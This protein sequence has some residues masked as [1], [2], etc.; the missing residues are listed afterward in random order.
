MTG[1]V[2]LLA[3]IIFVAGD[4]D[5][6]ANGWSPSTRLDVRYGYGLALTFVAAILALGAGV[7]V[8]VFNRPLEVPTDQRSLSSLR[9]RDPVDR[10]HREVGVEVE[11]EEGGL[12]EDGGFRNPVGNLHPNHHPHQHH[13]YRRG[14]DPPPDY[15]HFARQPT[16]DQDPHQQQGL[17]PPQAGYPR[18]QQDDDVDGD[19]AILHGAPR[20]PHQPQRF[21]PGSRDPHHQPRFG[22]SAAAESEGSG[23][24]GGGGFGSRGGPRRLVA[25]DL[26]SASGDLGE[27]TP[28][29]YCFG[30]TAPAG[31]RHPHQQPHQQHGQDRYHM[32]P[33]ADVT[34]DDDVPVHSG[35]QRYHHHHQLQ[36]S[37]ENSSP[38]HYSSHHLYSPRGGDGGRGGGWGLP[39]GDDDGGGGGDY[40]AAADYDRP[41][42]ASLHSCGEDGVALR[43]GRQ[44]S[45][46]SSSTSSTPSHARARQHERSRPLPRQ[47]S[48]GSEGSSRIGAHPGRHSLHD[49]TAD[50]DW[51]GA[52]ASARLEPPDVRGVEPLEARRHAARE[53]S[54]DWRKEGGEG[55]GGGRGARAAPQRHSRD[56]TEADIDVPSGLPPPLYTEV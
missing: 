11:V 45:S 46:L 47:T 16:K 30:R 22:S 43:Y 34:D 12:E 8:L 1:G 6:I 5:H 49:V 24:G 9:N 39:N 28:S 54:R 50:V 42:P 3:A 36:Q 29:Y 35:L 2:T 21:Q 31:D 25:H 40:D 20:P 37:P 18:A 14:T 7:A 15:R 17:P 56:V 19:G 13:R 4:P 51:H 33:V 48:A 27:P 53:N 55:E 44:L 26:D 32:S 38:P 10:L 23:R 52:G 41:R